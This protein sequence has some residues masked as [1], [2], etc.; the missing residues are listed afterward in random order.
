MQLGPSAPKSPPCGSSRCSNPVPARATQNLYMPSAAEFPAGFEVWRASRHG[1]DFGR[2]RIAFL[3]SHSLRVDSCRVKPRLSMHRR[4]MGGRRGR[5]SCKS[6]A[7]SACQLPTA[8]LAALSS[9]CASRKSPFIPWLPTGPYASHPGCQE[10]E[11]GKRAATLEAREWN[12]E[13]SY[14]ARAST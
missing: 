6:A 14:E 11:S 13:F 2:Q 3:A 5:R 10:E 4:I 7:H 9:A 1:E 12:R 8:A